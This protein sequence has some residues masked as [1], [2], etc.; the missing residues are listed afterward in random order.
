MNRRSARRTGGKTIEKKKRLIAKKRNCG[1][2]G[3]TSPTIPSTRKKIPSARFQALL[4]RPRTGR[5]SIEGTPSMAR[6]NIVPSYTIPAARGASWQRLCSFPSCESGNRSRAG[7]DHPTRGLRGLARRQRA[8][9]YCR[10]GPPFD[11]TGAVLVP[12]GGVLARSRSRAVSGIRRPHKLPVRGEGE[13]E[14]G[15]I[16][17]RVPRASFER[18]LSRSA[19]GPRDCKILG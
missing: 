7:C 13:E 10:P 3:M 12:N 14:M 11:G 8:P 2:T 16:P 18:G 6:G 17:R 15:E 19:R 9:L 4:R 5:C 1:I